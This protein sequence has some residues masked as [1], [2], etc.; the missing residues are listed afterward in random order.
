MFKWM[1]WGVKGFLTMF[2]KVHFSCLMACLRD[3]LKKTLLPD[4]FG[5][6][7]KKAKHRANDASNEVNRQPLLV[8]SLEAWK[9]CHVWPFFSPKSSYVWPNRITPKM[10]VWIIKMAAISENHKFFAVFAILQPRALCP[11]VLWGIERRSSGTTPWSTN[12]KLNDDQVIIMINIVILIINI[13]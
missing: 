3:I 11:C 13:K 1:G 2:K 4:V 8:T 7:L 10:P 6:V 9:V 12:K 5:D